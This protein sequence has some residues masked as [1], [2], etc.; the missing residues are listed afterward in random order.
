MELY[1]FFSLIKQLNTDIYANLCSQN[2]NSV[3]IV[4]I[5][6]D[7]IHYNKNQTVFCNSYSQGRI[8]PGATG[9]CPPPPAVTSSMSIYILFSKLHV[10]H[11]LASFSS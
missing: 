5:E 11:I 1:I 7:K 8:Q 10:N 9:A 6:Q 4:M 3:I 2:I